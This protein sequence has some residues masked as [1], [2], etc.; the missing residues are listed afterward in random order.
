MARNYPKERHSPQP[1]KHVPCAYCGKLKYHPASKIRNQKNLYCS[2]DCAQAALRKPKSDEPPLPRPAVDPELWN[3]PLEGL[4]RR[5]NP[6]NGYVNVRIKALRWEQE[7]RMVLAQKLGRPLRSGETGHHINGVRNDNR[8]ENLELWTSAPRWG[9]R[10]SE[11][12]CPHC[13]KLY[14]AA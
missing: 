1:G 14:A 3:T 2:R 12:T 6:T 5:E 13:G 11:V 7:H 4:E 10:A 8:P 9:Q